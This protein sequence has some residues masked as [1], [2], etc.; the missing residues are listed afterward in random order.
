MKQVLFCA[1][2]VYQLFNA[3][4]LRMTE[5]AECCCTLVL[6]DLT[7]WSED[8]LARLEK[9]GLFLHILRP[10]TREAEG[11]F[12]DLA[13]EEKLAAVEDPTLFFPEGAAPIEPMFDTIFC[14]IDHIYWKMLYRLH[15]V[16]GSPAKVC[17]FDEGVRAYTIDLPSTDDKPWFQGSYA[18]APFIRAVEAYYLYQPDLYA[19][20]GHSYQLRQLANPMKHP[21]VRSTLLEVFG[22]DA[23]LQE[24][25]IYLEDFF[26]QDRCISNDFALFEQV[27]AL[28]GRENIIVKRH[29]RGDVDR[30][31]PCGY[32]TME[33][34]VVPWEIQLLANDLRRKVLVSVSSTAI[35]TPFIIFRSDMHVISLEKM[36]AGI[37][38]AHTDAA[39]AAFFADVT[40]QVNRYEVHYHTPSSVEEL[41]QVLTYI[42]LLGE[43]DGQ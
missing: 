21:Q 39:F 43:Q 29:P 11:R 17:L 6:S 19:V 28:V 10:A 31:G 18:Q 12:R 26:F 38:P 41:R 3:I 4:T 42:S 16:N 15:T 35:L 27:A 34:S 37:N 7:L 14:P 22:S 2:S 25:F 5:C 8:M 40:R 20:K 1:E 24:P 23:P 33:R 9:T 36:F 32:K 13:P 30:F